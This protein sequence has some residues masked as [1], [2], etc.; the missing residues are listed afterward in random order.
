MTAF[1]EAEHF[2][3]HTAHLESFQIKGSGEGIE[4]P[5]NIAEGAGSRVRGVPGQVRPLTKPSGWSR[6]HLLAEIHAHQIVLKDVVIGTYIPA[7]TRLTIH[8]AMA[9]DTRKPCSARSGAGGV[10]L[11]PRMPQMR[12]VTESG[13]R[14]DLCLSLK[15]LYPRKKMEEVLALGNFL[16]STKSIAW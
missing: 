3:S 1:H 13:R 2:A 9:A 5:H 10:W 11:S 12:L 14:A 6:L 16:A 15:M 8:S 4:S 7:A